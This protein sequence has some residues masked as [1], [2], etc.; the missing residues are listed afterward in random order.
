[1]NVVLG[2]HPK[3][4]RLAAK[5]DANRFSVPQHVWAGWSRARQWHANRL[6]LDHSIWSG[7]QIVFSDHPLRARPG[8]WFLREIQYLLQNGQHILSPL[9]AHVA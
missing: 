6:F 9:D 1:M 3:Y 7:Y 5:L 8:S 2:H 4:L